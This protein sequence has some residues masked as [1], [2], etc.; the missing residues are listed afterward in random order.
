MKIRRFVEDFKKSLNAS[1]PYEH[2]PDRGKGVCNTCLL[3][4]GRPSVFMYVY[5]YV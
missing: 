5:M 1:K 2:P 3:Y 4:N